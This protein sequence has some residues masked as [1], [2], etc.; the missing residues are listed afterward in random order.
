MAAKS[1]NSKMTALVTLLSE[2]EK[3]INQNRPTKYKSNVQK[4]K[5][6]KTQ[7]G[8][9]YFKLVQISSL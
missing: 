4:Q 6:R 8:A 9:A 3:K 7:L 5:P 1:H 2:N